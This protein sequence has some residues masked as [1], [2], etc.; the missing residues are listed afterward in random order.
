MY[1]HRGEG[2]STDEEDRYLYAIILPLSSA[3]N[4]VL[5]TIYTC[6]LALWFLFVNFKS[7]HFCTT[8][9]SV[10]LNSAIVLQYYLSLLLRKLII[11]IWLRLE[12]SHFLELS[13]G[14]NI[15]V[16]KKKSWSECAFLQCVFCW[17]GWYVS[18]KFLNKNHCF[19]YF[20]CI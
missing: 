13:A 19:W 6:F 3:Q 5:M 7:F 4:K 17:A 15:C 18:L 14:F 9:C 1:L 8:L 10:V 16:V 11:Y 20:L 12:F 2:V